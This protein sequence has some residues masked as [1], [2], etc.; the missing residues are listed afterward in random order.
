MIRLLLAFSIWIGLALAAMANAAVVEFSARNAPAGTQRH[1][2]VIG[3]SNYENI[4]K[5]P[6]PAN[7][8]TAMAR[9]LSNVGFHVYQAIDLDRAGMTDVIGQFLNAVTPGS[10]ALVYYAG[11]GVELDGQNYLLPIDIRKLDPSQQYSLRTDGISLTGV[12]Q[13]LEWRKPRV[14]V[15]ILDAC[16]NNPF[17]RAGT[18]SLG[19]TAGLGRVDPPQGTLVLYAAAAGETALDNLGAGDTE[20]N[21]LFT[22]K[23]LGL[24]E[25]P[26]LEIRAMVQELKDRVYEA[27]LTEARHTQRPSYYDGLIGKFYFVPASDEPVATDPCELIVR[28]E[29]S[30]SELL[31]SDPEEGVAACTQALVRDPASPLFRELLDL[32]TEQRA[33]QKA[34]LSENP[35]FSR[36]YAEVY[37]GGSFIEAVRLHLVSIEGAEVEPAV[38]LPAPQAP[39]EAPV[40]AAPLP[41]PAPVAPA[42]DRLALARELQVELNRVG[43][44]LGAPD[45]IWGRKSERALQLY[46]DRQGVVLASLDPSE[47]LLEQLKATT[48]RVC[49]LVCSAKQVEK[50][51][52]CVA[53]TCPKGQS[54]SSKG[55]CFTPQV[56][57]PASNGGG[58][59][60]G[61][62]AK[63]F[64]FNGQQFCE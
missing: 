29:M 64:E 35:V 6:N 1:A 60:G 50:N 63:C 39:V 34:L 23:L 10:E 31:L 58:G 12:L 22:R 56:A 36:S 44:D 2:L 38:P 4:A 16:R 46:S 55:E 26:G 40:V 45:G 5:L 51:G 19:S 20:A 9:S 32:A 54:L 59:G 24:I 42:I 47:A 52:T 62:G 28:R 25:Q 14:S 48:S 15:V 30:R 7:D 27:A 61:G 17:E 18:R 33:A 13:D 49:P 21:G 37:P 53:K 3:N 41:D 57:Q 43:C 11:H 8:A